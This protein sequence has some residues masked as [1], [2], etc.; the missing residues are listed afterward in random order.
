MHTADNHWMECPSILCHEAILWACQLSK[1][2]RTSLYFG[3]L[4]WI[5]LATWFPC[6]IMSPLPFKFTWCTCLLCFPLTLGVQALPFLLWR[7]DSLL[8]EVDISTPFNNIFPLLCLELLE[9]FDSFSDSLSSS[10]SLTKSLTAS[11]VISAA[12]S[13]ACSLRNYKKYKM[14]KTLDITNFFW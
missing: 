10:E 3:L 1:P 12:E 7:T 8:S 9:P 4:T 11:V 2:G 13:A 6:S 5:I 14:F